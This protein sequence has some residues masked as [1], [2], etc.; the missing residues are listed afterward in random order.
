MQ[1]IIPMSMKR[2]M[3]IW[4]GILASTF[5]FK[6]IVCCLANHMARQNLIYFSVTFTRGHFMNKKIEFYSLVSKIHRHSSLGNKN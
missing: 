4:V 6:N 3:R 1:I 2:P 5:Y